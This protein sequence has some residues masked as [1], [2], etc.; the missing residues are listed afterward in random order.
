M[1]EAESPTDSPLPDMH[2]SAPGGADVELAQTLPTAARLPPP[3]EIE[4]P[5]REL[6]L[7][8]ARGGR[9]HGGTGSA[10][11]EG[12]VE[13][14]V[15]ASAS[16][17]SLLRPVTVTIVLT[18]FL[19]HAMAESPEKI[20]GSFSQLMV[21][22][23][24][25]TDTASTIAS[26]V[27]LNSLVMVGTLFSVTTLLLLLYKFRCY[28]IIYGW[29]FLSV[30][31]LLLL[32]GGFVAQQLITLYAIPLDWPSGESGRKARRAQGEVRDGDTV[33]RRGS[34]ECR[35]GRPRGEPQL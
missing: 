6:Q 35:V 28:L 33:G 3:T 22:E 1:S 4:P 29:L 20:A 2:S 11:D 16:V 34:Q 30:G 12:D 17:N 25:D 23:E 14:G 13:D 9:E 24:H 27:L 5:L 32:F 19:V 7:R 21:Y 8:P 10:S 15:S 18:V 26:G 31:S